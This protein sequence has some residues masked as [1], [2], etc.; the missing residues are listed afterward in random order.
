MCVPHVVSLCSETLLMNI[1]SSFTTTGTL[2]WNS[3]LLRIAGIRDYS[4]LVPELDGYVINSCTCNALCL[5]VTFTS[6]Q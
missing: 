4:E 6:C 3:R 2:C 5:P 1:Q